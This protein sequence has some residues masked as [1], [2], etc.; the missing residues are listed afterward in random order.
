MICAVVLIISSSFVLVQGGAMR[1][2]A[3]G[4][5]VPDRIPCLKVKL[6]LPSYAPSIG[7]T[8]GPIPDNSTMKKVLGSFNVAIY[9]SQGF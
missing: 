2:S 3:G 4:G 9:S 7:K 6:M 1:A 5:P 8:H